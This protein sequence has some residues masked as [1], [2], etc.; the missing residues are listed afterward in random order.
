MNARVLYF[1]LTFFFASCAFQTSFLRQI[2]Y[3]Y[4]DK[5]LVISPLSAYQVLGLT[6][7][8]AKGKTLEQML[9]TLGHKYLSELNRR[10]R[11]IIKQINE[12]ETVEIAN[13]VMTKVRPKRKF[14]SVAKYYNAAVETLKDVEQV[15]NWCDLKTHGKIKKLLDNL[16]KDAIMVLLNAIYF[17]GTWVKE[18]DKEKTA[19]KVFYNFNDEKKGVEV[20]TMSMKEKFNYYGDQDVQ[21][22]ELPYKNDSMSA[23][24]ILPNKE[25][26]INKYIDELTDEKLHALLKRMNGQDL[27]FQLPKFEL[28]FSALLN[29]CLQKLGMILPFTGEADFSRLIRGDAS[30]SRVVQKSYLKVDET[31]SEAA[32]GTAVVIRKSIPPSMIVDRPFLF[33]LK[34]ADLPENNEMIIMAKINELK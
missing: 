25:T 8:G 31:G 29:K 4:K 14:L 21:V 11:N 23:I 15:N 32:S 34:N 1:I 2:N 28:E 13:A 12:Y 33:M 10:N 6:A 5:N 22:I 7:N 9:S 16:E 27:F 30:I 3:E 20:D 19:K 24:I 26:D 17:K 18:F